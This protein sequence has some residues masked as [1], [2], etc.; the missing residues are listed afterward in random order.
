MVLGD[1]VF[2][3]LD[4]LSIYIEAFNPAPHQFVEVPEEKPSARQSY[5]ASHLIKLH[6]GC[7]HVKL[8]SWL[9]H[10]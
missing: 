5:A 10:R 7:L 8:N 9:L 2:D 3:H 6:L 4:R 1:Q